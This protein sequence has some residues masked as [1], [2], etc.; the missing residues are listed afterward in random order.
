MNIKR[1]NLTL[2]LNLSEALKRIEEL[3]KEKDEEI[4]RRE[5]LEQSMSHQA[6]EN[7]RVL[8]NEL[9]SLRERVA[10][11]A[12]SDNEKERLLETLRVRFQDLANEKDILNNSIGHLKD[13]VTKLNGEKE[14]IRKAFED[15][16]EER[17]RKEGE[18]KK[19]LESTL[20]HNLDRSHKAHQAETS[21]LKEE[22]NTL[23]L[24]LANLEREKAD[25]E[26]KIQDFRRERPIVDN[27]IA[28][29]QKK[30]ESL[31]KERE[32]SKEKDIAENSLL[33][34]QIKKMKEE[35]RQIKESF[36][37]LRIESEKRENEYREELEKMFAEE[38][39][40]NKG[41][42]QAEKASLKS[43]I[44]N[45]RH[46]LSNASREKGDLEETI[47]D[48]TREKEALDKD[49]V[50]LQER[51]NKLKGERDQIKNSLEN[52]R[53]KNLE[54]LALVESRSDKEHK[55]K[56]ANLQ[57]KI[58]ALMHEKVVSE[59]EVEESKE[60][61]L[62]SEKEK[63][64]MERDIAMLKEKLEKVR[65]EAQKSLDKLRVRMESELAE[66]RAEWEGR[67]KELEESLRELGQQVAA[68]NDIINNKNKNEEESLL[69]E[70][71]IQ[72]DK[73]L[74]REKDLLEKEKS[75]SHEL[76]MEMM[77]LKKKFLEKE[78]E[79]KNNSSLVEKLNDQL[80]ASQSL[81]STLRNENE[82][83]K[84]LLDRESTDKLDTPSDEETQDVSTE[85][86]LETRETISRLLETVEDLQYRKDM[87]FTSKR[88]E[89][90]F[91]QGGDILHEFLTEIERYVRGNLTR[92]ISNAQNIKEATTISKEIKDVDKKIVAQL[93]HFL[94]KNESLLKVGKKY[95]SLLKIKR[96]M[97]KEINESKTKLDKK[98]KLLADKERQVETLSEELEET[99]DDL[100]RERRRRQILISDWELDKRGVE[101]KRG[102]DEKNRVKDKREREKLKRMID[103]KE[104]EA[105]ERNK[106]IET[107]KEE[108]R[109]KTK[110][111]LDLT[112]R[113]DELERKSSKQKRLIRL[114][115]DTDYDDEEDEEVGEEEGESEKEFEVVKGKYSFFLECV[116]Q[117]A[118]CVR[119]IHITDKLLQA[120]YVSVKYV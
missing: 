94:N 42:H 76:K 64:L 7:Q 85:G 74:C 44:S 89:E 67:N 113:I 29:L 80:K 105:K 115:R 107:L 51:V 40:R 35:N 2:E 14:E 110:E 116:I 8:Q 90:I 88:R 33:K 79:E 1:D 95:E 109:K 48:M 53:Q 60:K 9:S 93:K 17:N 32:S 20:A 31:Q 102:E 120:L 63:V 37:D 92:L 99:K 16:Q 25:L 30:V 3:R 119:W 65:G 15:F 61:L 13:Q 34:T 39:D 104:V 108:I 66:E 73:Q 75:R 112:L 18:Y 10:S 81:L 28:L 100:E 22:N 69:A 77:S 82:T 114:F 72:N 86:G 101:E 21:S 68:K 47:Q 12:K 52:L 43:E 71:M 62:A 55:E 56:E 103:I 111:S 78:D 46:A 24:F 54:S 4:L 27:N 106:R 98:T 96:E 117:S 83:L 38:R 118:N 91:D 59:R 19:E 5:S 36:D 6:S 57:I 84:A 49:A 45:L 70:Y 87:P 97:D 26:E 50:S 41:T 23:K 58:T 11:F